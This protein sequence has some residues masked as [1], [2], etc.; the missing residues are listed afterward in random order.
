M[1]REP[2]RRPRILF[3]ADRNILAN[4]AYNAFSASPEDALIQIEP[5]DIRKKG[6]VPK[7]GSLFFTIYQTFMASAATASPLP[8]VREPIAELVEVEVSDI[9]SVYG[10]MYILECADGSFYV[11]STKELRVRLVQ[12]QI[13]D[14]S[15]HTKNRRPLKLV[16]YET[17]GRIHEAFSREKQVQG[18]SR[19]KKTALIKGNISKLKQLARALAGS[20]TAGAGAGFGRLS[21][22]V[23]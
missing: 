15:Q 17:F 8:V 6:K 12:H 4:Q 2:T 13:G 21:Q 3:L 14:G 19:A 16:Y 20:A 10:Y 11:G 7:N 18:R 22:Q 1:S 5:A 23:W 9:R